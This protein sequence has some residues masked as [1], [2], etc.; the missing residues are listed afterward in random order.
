MAKII[1]ERCASNATREELRNEDPISGEA[2]LT[3]WVLA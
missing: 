2:V 1:D 3:Q